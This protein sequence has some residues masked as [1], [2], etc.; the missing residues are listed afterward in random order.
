MA[1]AESVE[2]AGGARFQFL[3]DDWDES[4]GVKFADADLIGCPAR[5][6]VSRRSLEAGGVEVKVRWERER[7]VVPVN[8]TPVLLQQ[9]LNQFIILQ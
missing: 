7:R 3:R 1:A 9:I 8:S 4:A 5:L 2:R 6:M